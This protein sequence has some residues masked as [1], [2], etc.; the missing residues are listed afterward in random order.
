MPRARFSVGLYVDVANIAM[1]GG[2]GM[3][4]DVL[5]QFACHDGGEVVRLNAYVAYDEQRAREDRDYRYR[6]NNFYSVLR[7]LGYKV[8]VKNVKRYMDEEGK[9]F[10]KANSD[11]DMAVD[12][13]LQSENL[14]RVIMLTGDG[15]FVQV[16]RALQNKGCRVEAIA[17]KNVSLELRQEVDFFISGYLVPHLLPVFH[18][19][20][21]DSAATWG[22]VGSRVRGVCY[23]YKYDRKFGFM[24]FIRE[25]KSNLW[26]TDTRRDDSPYESAY[27]NLSEINERIPLNSLPSRDIIFEF[28]IQTGLPDGFAAKNIKLVHEL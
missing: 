10:A 27:F 19:I 15:D 3:R 22:E 4:Y 1:N 20:P 13:L 24:R 12:S 28:E 25:A 18:E 5:R 6:T 8:V 7:D 21:S 17:F 11:L 2:F 26:I 16:V 23:D 14:D 9:I